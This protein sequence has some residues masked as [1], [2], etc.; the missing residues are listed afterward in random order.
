MLQ[1][2][3]YLLRFGIESAFQQDNVNPYYHGCSKIILGQF[4]CVLIYNSFP[5]HS[6]RQGSPRSLSVFAT[7]W[8]LHQAH[9]LKFTNKYLPVIDSPFLLNSHMS[10]TSMSW[11]LEK[12]WK[13]IL[14][15]WH[16]S[17]H[18]EKRNCENYP[19][20][21]TVNSCVYRVGRARQ[22]L[23]PEKNL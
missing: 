3:Q 11:R 19:H 9:Y 18:G 2:W 4:S 8:R 6:R 5:E 20:S 22:V 1:P 23:P 7:A 21:W 13:R 14:Q 16:R 10:N 17:L 12:K 15:P